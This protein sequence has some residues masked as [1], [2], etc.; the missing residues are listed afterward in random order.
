MA[1][2]GIAKTNIESISKGNVEYILSE[3]IPSEDNPDT[4]NKYFTICGSTTNVEKGIKKKNAS[5]KAATKR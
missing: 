2:N 5:R 3:V 1:T 4:K